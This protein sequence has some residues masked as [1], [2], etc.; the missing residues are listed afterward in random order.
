MAK[1]PTTTADE[2][3]RV[4]TSTFGV[5]VKGTPESGH[6]VVVSSEDAIQD[7]FRSETP[8]MADGLL[9][10]CLKVLKSNEAS[11][12][13]AGNDERAFMLAAI[14]EIAP[15]DAVERMLAVQMAATHVAMVRSG[16]WLAT[17]GTVDQLRVHYSGYHALARTYTTQM[18]AL[19]KH[20]S[21]GKQT[22]TVQHVNIESGGQAIVGDVQTGRG[23]GSG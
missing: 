21:G 13:F 12:D 1:T 16:R 10:H 11:D 8:E 4:K 14:K 5:T 9:T 7:L 20:R 15:R 23:S 19:R 18:D 17:T 3:R 2:P 22:V 6:Q